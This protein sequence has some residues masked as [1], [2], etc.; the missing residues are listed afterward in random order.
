MAAMI[1]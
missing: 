1:Y